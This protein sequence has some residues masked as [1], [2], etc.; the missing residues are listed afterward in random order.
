[1]HRL[2]P[3]CLSLMPL[4]AQAEPP[5]V[6]TDIAAVASLVAQV[7]T[8]QTEPALLVPP[9][10]GAHDFALRPSDASALS[11]ADLV[12]WLGPQMT[13]WLEAPLARLAPEAA[14][15][16]L[17]QTPGFTPLRA[18]DG[19]IDPHAFLDPAIAGLWLSEIAASLAGAD[20]DNTE[21]YTANAEAARAR[22]TVLDATLRAELAP[23]QGRG[24]IAPHA[25]FAYFARAYGL[26]LA[27]S[28]ADEHAS[29]PGAAHI[30]DLRALAQSGTAVC[31]LTDA[32]TDAR[33]AEVIGAGTG[34]R[35]AQA[36]AEGAGLA[37]GPMLYEAL[38]QDLGQTIAACLA[39]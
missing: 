2:I 12:I 29:A 25:A 34:A 22:L 19:D 20:P 28:I 39:P 4:A 7:T 14:Q 27:G 10:G 18:A 23:L 13:P 38:M 11:R 35:T 24:F 30:A 15:L 1:M 26:T 31:I 8:G 9:G 37:P 21:T 33:W 32:E 5:Q 16:G 6:L 3:L 17:L 36:D